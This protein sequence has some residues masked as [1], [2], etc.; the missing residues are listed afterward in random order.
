[1][2]I[3]GK[4]ILGLKWT[5]FSTLILA[6]AA[7]LKISILARYLETSDFG[8]MAL[9]T[10][11]L[12][13]INLFSDMGLSTAILHK[14]NIKK[15]TYSSLFWF[16]LLFCIL[17]Y[18]IIVSLAPIIGNFYGEPQL[19]SLIPL[20][21]INVVLSGIGTQFKTIETK[22]LLFKNIGIIEIIAAVLSL[23]L[24]I[25]LA[26]NGYGVLSLV[27][28]SMAQYIVSN[29]LFFIT[30][31]NKYGLLFHFKI[32][33][34]LPFLKIGIYQ[35]GGQIINYFNRDLD[36]ILIGKLFSVEVLGGYSLA[37]QLVLRPSQVV[38]P[39][40]VK[41]AS[42]ALAKF[43]FNIT[44]L[45]TNY[46]K[47]I[48]IVSTINIPIY[49]GII[50][51]APTVVELL[52]GAGF[53]NIIILVRILSV[54]MIFRAIGNPIGSLVIATGRTELE[55]YWNLLNLLVMPMFIYFGATYGIVEVTISL[56]LAMLLL[57]VP[58]WKL[59]V[60]KMTGATLIEYLKAIIS[61]NGI[62]K[63]M[64]AK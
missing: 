28:S 2:S 21:S 49:L 44:L 17:L 12:G 39:I 33:E 10:F 30:G 26:V 35:V 64:T 61:F 5:S 40:L 27:Y 53:E 18:L 31:V 11:V 63:I 58:S 37:K 41:V 46:L 9:I 43:Q 32:S 13:F 15:K 36:I 29:I 19:N 48:S 25:Y 50:I 20:L 3:K 6:V 1:M 42:P 8:L 38:N 62:K 4:V 34:V 24:A 56:T 52:Y 14:Q 22:N 23:A 59:L 57:F 45:K 54:Y 47:L 55:F 60:N 51:F 7:I 16:N